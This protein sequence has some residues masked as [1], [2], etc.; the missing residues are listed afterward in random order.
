[1]SFTEFC[2]NCPSIYGYK[3]DFDKKF[4]YH[5][6]HIEP[7]KNGTYTRHYTIFFGDFTSQKQKQ[8]VYTTRQNFEFMSDKEAIKLI[9][10]M[11]DEKIY[12]KG[13]HLIKIN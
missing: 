6:Q 8:Y 9:G 13:N 11:F 7:R 1:M 4:I 2:S 5:V 10:E 3:E 12:V